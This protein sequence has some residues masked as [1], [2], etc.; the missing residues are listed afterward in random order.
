MEIDEDIKNA[1]AEIT[2]ETSSDQPIHLDV[3]KRV[4]LA[5]DVS[6]PIDP[7]SNSAT[8]ENLTTTDASTLLSSEPNEIYSSK[9]NIASVTSSARPSTRQSVENLVKLHAR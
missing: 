9:N 5:P 1:D 4:E 6:H 8:N 2:N 3:D 7:E